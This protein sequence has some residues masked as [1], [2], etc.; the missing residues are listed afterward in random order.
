MFNAV[1]QGEGVL[2]FLDNPGRLGKTFVYIVLLT[3]VQWDE[4]VAIEVAFSGIVAFLLE[5]G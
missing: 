4:H 1:A 3:L 2:F 5:D